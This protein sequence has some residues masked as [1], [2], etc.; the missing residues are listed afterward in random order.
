MNKTRRTALYGLLIALALIISYVETQ[1][2]ALIAVPGMKI[3]LTNIVVLMALYLIGEKSAVVINI[4]RIMAVSMLFGNG[5]S[6]IYSLAGGLLSGAVMI[7]L[8][9]LDKFSMTGVSIA[10]GISHNCGQVAAAMLMLNTASLAWYLAVLWF[11]GMVSG[12]VVG[13]LGSVICTRLE[14]ALRW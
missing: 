13:L 14:K 11:S 6:F 10:G 8:K 1:I 12:L 7:V 2:P 3:G 9:R 4:I 5:V